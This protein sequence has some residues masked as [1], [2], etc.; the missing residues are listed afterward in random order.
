MLAKGVFQLGNCHAV[1]ADVA[2][3]E[4]FPMLHSAMAEDEVQHEEAEAG[5]C[6]KPRVTVAQEMLYPLVEL[7]LVGSVNRGVRKAERE[8][9]GECHGEKVAG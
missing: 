1:M 4:E 5:M 6:C 7:Q 8:E 9:S 3:E 2:R